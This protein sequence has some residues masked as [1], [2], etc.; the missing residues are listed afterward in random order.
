MCRSSLW[1]ESKF[2]KVS[3]NTCRLEKKISIRTFEWMFYLPTWEKIYLGGNQ[4]MG[5]W[6][7]LWD[8]LEW[9]YLLLHDSL[10]LGR[11]RRSRGNSGRL[12]ILRRIR[13]NKILHRWRGS[14]RRYHFRTRRPG[15]RNRWGFCERAGC[16]WGI[17]DKNFDV[18]LAV[19]M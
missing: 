14:V 7:I 2:Y 5:A 17:K 11:G 6:R 4:N 13:I 16:F 18:R 19:F 8:L 10:V 12:C 1:N 9:V 15:Q 3:E